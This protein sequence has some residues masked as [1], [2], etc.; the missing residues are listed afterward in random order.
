MTIEQNHE[1]KF[2]FNSRSEYLNFLHILKWGLESSK[3]A[4]NTFGFE[5]QNIQEELKKLISQLKD[6]K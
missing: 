2:S 1:L 5:D 4:G 6:G 3:T